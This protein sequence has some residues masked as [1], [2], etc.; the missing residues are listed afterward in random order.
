MDPQFESFRHN[1][2]KENNPDRRE[3]E[4]TPCCYG[5]GIACFLKFK[6]KLEYVLLYEKFLANPG[7]DTTD[8]YFH[9]LK[10]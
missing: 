3:E 8:L 6:D 7:M 2:L 10:S 5:G 1:F 9:I 4:K